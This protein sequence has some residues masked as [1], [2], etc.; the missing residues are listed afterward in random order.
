MGWHKISMTICLHHLF[1]RFC[2]SF[3][4]NEVVY[5]GIEGL[6][7][8]FQYHWLLSCQV[9]TEICLISVCMT[10]S[11]SGLGKVLCTLCHF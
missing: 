5:V 4:V 8:A 1:L 9:A 10:L 11:G 6:S 7:S 3:Q 2:P